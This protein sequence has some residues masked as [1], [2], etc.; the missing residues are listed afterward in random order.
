MN[1]HWRQ[2]RRW[3]EGERSPS[4]FC[5]VKQHRKVGLLGRGRMYCDTLFQYF[6]IFSDNKQNNVVRRSLFFSLFI[7][8]ISVNSQKISPFTQKG[9]L[10]MSVRMV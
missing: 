7:A 3:A 1:F 5:A 2:R 4:A 8:V 6:K 9:G 10:F